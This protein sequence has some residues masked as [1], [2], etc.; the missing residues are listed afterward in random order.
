MPA[1]DQKIENYATIDLCDEVKSSH[2]GFLIKHQI[3]Y[4]S[5]TRSKPT[6]QVISFIEI[7]NA[8]SHVDNNSHSHKI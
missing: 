2:C 7:W 6:Q 5:F 8:I 1:A 3:N 4:T